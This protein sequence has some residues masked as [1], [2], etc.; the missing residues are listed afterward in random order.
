MADTLSHVS[1]SGV[2]LGLL[3]GINP[4]CTNILVVIIIATLLAFLRQI[5]R[6]YSEISIAILMS[7]GMAVALVLMEISAGGITLSVTQFLFGSI[8]TIHKT[9]MD[10]TRINDNY[11][12][13]IFN[14]SKTYV[15]SYI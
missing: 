8:V 5:Y 14:I 15:C 12:I 4:T 11:R 7:V 1:L 6:T 9:N 2:A 3:I 10:V 13:I